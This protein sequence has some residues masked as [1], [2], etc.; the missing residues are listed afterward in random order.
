MR[1]SRCEYGS[2]PSGRSAFSDCVLGVATWGAYLEC[3]HGKLGLVRF[4]AAGIGLSLQPIDSWGFENKWESTLSTSAPLVENLNVTLSLNNISFALRML[5]M[6][7]EP[8]LNSLEVDQLQSLNCVA[9][10]AKQASPT[11]TQSTR[12]DDMAF[13]AI[14]S[15]VQA[16]TLGPNWFNRVHISL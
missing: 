10:C 13:E 8:A 3:V 14:P 12:V 1:R 6:V 11:S 9:S 15:W 16:G 2:V 4:S 5:S 7:S